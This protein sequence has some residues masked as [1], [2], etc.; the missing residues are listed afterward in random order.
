MI[1]LA[2]WIV[3]TGIGAMTFECWG[4]ALVLFGVAWLLI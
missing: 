3:A 2:L 1:T 4:A